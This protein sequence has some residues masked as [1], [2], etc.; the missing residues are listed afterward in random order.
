MFITYALYSPSRHKFIPSNEARDL[1][2][3]SGFHVAK[4]LFKGK[5]HLRDL[6]LYAEGVSAYSTHPREGIVIKITDSNQQYKL[7]RQDYQQ[8][9]AWDNKVL[10]KQPSFD[11]E[12]N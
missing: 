3:T 4:L 5:T 11:K 1:L 12:H 9:T 2:T 8:N 6:L 7:I 10:H